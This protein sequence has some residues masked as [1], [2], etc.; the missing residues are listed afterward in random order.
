MKNCNFTNKYNPLTTLV[1]SSLFL[2]AGL[3]TWANANYLTNF[4]D[5]NTNQL[6]NGLNQHS[7]HIVVLGDS[8]TAGDTMTDALRRYLQDELGDGGM[9]WAMPMYIKGQRMARFGYDNNA[10][11]YVYSRTNTHENYTLGGMIAKPNTVGATL[12]LKPKH[13]ESPQQLMM[14]LRQDAG[15]GVFHATDMAGRTFEI[16]SPTKDGTWQTVS[17]GQVQLPITLT[18]AN[19]SNLAIGGWWAF[20]PNG[21]GAVVSALGINGAQL[22]QFN[23]WNTQAWQRELGVISPTVV[24]LAYGTNEGYNAITGEQ[25]SHELTTRI[26]QIRKAVPNAVVL[27]ISAPES[28]KSLSGRCGVRPS[29]LDD[30]Q[31]AQRRVAQHERTLYWDWQ[32]YMGGVCTMKSWVNSG[33]ASKDGV[34]FLATGYTQIGHQLAKDL[35][36]LAE[37]KR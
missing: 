9:G 7:V 15:D 6:I 37:P 32:G 2:L 13:T 17:L 36:M 30:V 8:H 35:L 25:M 23:R 18:N 12:T 21:R 4:G 28:L 3:A 5:P 10:F 24:A 33:R 34:H 26:R 29:T 22:S 31:S 27:I 11:S 19:A 16:E 1:K 14:T 20:N